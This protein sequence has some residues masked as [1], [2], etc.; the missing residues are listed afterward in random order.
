MLTPFTSSIFGESGSSSGVRIV[1]PASG[2]GERCRQLFGL[3]LSAATIG[4]T[5]TEHHYA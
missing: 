4:Q 2:L 1:T 3:A 5:A